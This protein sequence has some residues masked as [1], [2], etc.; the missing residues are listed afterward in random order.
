[1]WDSC[2]H[3]LARSGTRSGPEG[4][5]QGNNRAEEEG[6]AL[7]KISAFQGA[8]KAK[9]EGL[10]SGFFFG[11]F[12][13]KIFWCT[14]PNIYKLGGKKIMLKKNLLKKKTTLRENQLG[15]FS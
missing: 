6:P 5:L 4:K 13:F 1:L 14:L 2:W 11:T 8:G 12:F 9:K 10:C 3:S 15:T 7:R